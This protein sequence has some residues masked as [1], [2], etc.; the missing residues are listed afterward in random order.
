MMEPLPFPIEIQPGSPA[1]EQVVQ[2]VHRALATGLLAEGDPF[3]SVR[4]LGRAARINPN[5]AH[6]VV[7]ALVA[8]GTL[9]VLPGRGTRVAPTLRLT[10]HQRRG[11]IRG[12]L[13]SLVI[14]ARRLGFHQDELSRAVAETWRSL[15]GKPSDF[16]ES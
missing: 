6:K 5:T 16:E 10:P 11:R 4:A 14:E 12:S 3:P 13:E 9:E 15:D 2:A 1:Y 8:D 7:Q